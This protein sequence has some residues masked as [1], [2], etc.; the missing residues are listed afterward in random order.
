MFVESYWL[1]TVVYVLLCESLQVKLVEL[2]LEP[3]E[4]V[5]ISKCPLPTF[6]AKALAMVDP[7]PDVFE[8]LCVLLIVDVGVAAA[9]EPILNDELLTSWPA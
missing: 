8:V 5:A 3:H 1:N 7:L 2:V 4:T 6:E 9:D